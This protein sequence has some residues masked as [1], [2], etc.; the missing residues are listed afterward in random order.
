[1]NVKKR[2]GSLEKLSVD[3]LNKVVSWAC[4]GLDAN[5]SDV[6][7][8]ANIQL[9]DGIKTTKIHEV[10]VNSAIDLITVQTPDYQYVASKLFSFFN[11]KQIF[12]VF[13]DEDMP[14]VKSVVES[15]IKVGLYDP[16]L[17]NKYDDE[18]W[19]KINEIVDHSQD[20]KLTIASYQ[21]MHATYLAKNRNTGYVY[22]TP[23]YAFVI[24]AA[25]LFSNIKE[26][27]EFYK[28]LTTKWLNIP[29]P[30]M[31]GVRTGTRQYASC[32]L[33]D[34]ADDLD[35]IYASNHAIGRFVSRRAGI[36]INMGRIRSFGSEIRK[37][38]ATHTGIIPFL[39]LTEAAT[40]SCS[41]GGL[42]DGSTTVHFQI[43]NKEIEEILVLKN[44]KG[45]DDNRVRRLDYSIQVSKLFWSRMV[46]EEWITLFSTSDVPGLYEAFGTPKFDELYL[47]YENDK[48]IPSKKVKGKELL[49]SIVSERMNTGRIYIQNI[50]NV[51]DQT[52]FKDKVSMSNLCQEINLA[53][54]PIYDINDGLTK[55]KKI[56]VKHSDFQVYQD[57]TQDDSIKLRPSDGIMLF[58]KD[59]FVDKK[60]SKVVNFCSKD[61]VENNQEYTY[62]D[63]EFELMYGDKPGNIALCMLGGINL[64]NLNGTDT[65][66]R[67]E[68]PIY[69]MVKALDKVID[70]QDYPVAA[71]AKQLKTRSIGV[72][73]T[74]F[75]YFLAKNNLKY[76]EAET[77]NVVDELFEHIQFYLMKASMEIAKEVGPCAYFNRTKYA[78]GKLPIDLYNKRVDELVDRP[79][80]CDW[81]WLR[82]EIAKYGLRNSVLSAIMPSESSSVVT[83]STNGI[84]PPR[85]L[86]TTKLNK[87][88]NIKMVVPSV[89]SLANKYTLAWDIKNNSDINKIVCV[90]QKWVDQ[91][92]S[93]NHYYNPN[94]YE[95]KKVP[96]KVVIEDMV[97]FYKYGGKQLYYAN[98]LDTIETDE[99]S[100]STQDMDTGCEG[101]ACT[102]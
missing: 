58:E 24:I 74:N 93:V 42:R 99:T 39:K 26:I 73:V 84:E 9:F 4:E 45:T 10:L 21:K 37:G 96:S 30:I 52:P 33:I 76:G 36:G 15:N 32:T 6:L 81:E 12:G 54:S 46:K 5:P 65:F 68:R 43:W 55:Y 48:K 14:S 102:L 79:L 27:K 75:A 87:G 83:N 16:T 64:G 23:Q 60:L 29:T 78:D 98:T 69:Y 49:L 62:V 19:A 57:L 8:N 67:L 17:I 3:K 82:G 95:D 72:G 86:V 56:K 61:E 22:E 77:L 51:N 13:K 18:T 63:Q 53:T 85:S 35:S 80:T 59:N 88:G 28:E 25:T 89:K 70:L 66:N 94:D 34:V 100:G 44:N 47:K 50:D 7:M 31:A 90:I 41:Q 92:I 91:G 1:M 97:E 71:S 38:E 101:G 20:S 11:R 40:K 2:D